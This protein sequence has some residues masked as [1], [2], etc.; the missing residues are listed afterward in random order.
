VPPS[1]IDLGSF[2]QLL[3]QTRPPAV[4]DE[5]ADDV[6]AALQRVVIAEKHG[7]GRSGATGVSI[8]FPNSQLYGS[9]LAGPQSYTAIAGR[10]A[11]ESLWDDFLTYHYTGQTFQALPV[12]PTIPGPGAMVSAPGTGAFELSAID[13]SSTVAAPGRPVLMSMDITGENVGYVLFFTGFYDRQSNSIFVADMDYIESSVTQEIDGVYYPVWPEPEFT[14]Q[15][16]WE[17]LMFAISDGTDSVTAALKPEEY[18]ATYEEA[19][20]SVDGIYTYTSGESRYARLYFRDGWLRQVFGFTGQDGTGA[21]REIHPQRGDTFTV[22]EKW[23]DLD[24][25]GNVVQKATQEGGTLT[26]GNQMFRWEELDAAP[27]QYILGFI[28]QDL[29]GNSLEQYATVE[30]E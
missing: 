9:P 16:E 18:G 8:Y 29:D 3:N 26:F 4:V 30:V 21:P 2:A 12:E 20:Y 27:G 19:T 5:A 6:L 13:L 24:A 23:L 10:F 28:V 15:F 25:Q 17:P 14:L 1:Y 7:S 22:L 11:N